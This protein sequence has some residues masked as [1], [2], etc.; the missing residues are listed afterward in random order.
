MGKTVKLA[1]LLY[2]FR[3]VLKPVRSDSWDSILRKVPS[4]THWP[5]RE[6]HHKVA[7]HGHL[8]H[9]GRD[10]RLLCMDGLERLIDR[11]HV[12]LHSR[13][14]HL[15]HLPSCYRPFRRIAAHG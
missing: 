5:L 4:L 11:Q 6:S 3:Y 2:Q 12:L 14:H 1:R 13:P 7:I 15:L 8:V 9:R 10:R